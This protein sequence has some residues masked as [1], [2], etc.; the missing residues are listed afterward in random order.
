M[1]RK[2][3]EEDKKYTIREKFVEESESHGLVVYYTDDNDS[4]VFVSL[5]LAAI[6]IM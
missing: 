1:N 6:T 3:R 2:R 4:I 5:T